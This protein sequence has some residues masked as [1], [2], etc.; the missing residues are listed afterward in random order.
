MQIGAIR[1]ATAYA[2]FKKARWP[3]TDGKPFCPHCGTL[4]CYELTDSRFKSS[5]RECRAVFTVTSGTAFAWRKLSFKKMLL[6]IWLV[7]NSVKGKAALQLS[8]ELG[9]AYKTAYVLLMK[10]REVVAARRGDMKLDGEVGIDGKYARGHVRPENRAEDRVDRRRRN[11]NR[12]PDRLCAL[13]VRQRGVPGQTLTRVIRGEDAK[14]AWAAVRDHVGRT[15]TVFADEHSS[16]DDLVGLNLVNRVNHS[17]ACRSEDGA[18]TN[19]VESFFSRLERAYVGIQHRFS[20]RYIDWYV[21]DIAW[22]ED[23]RRTSNGGLT[24]SLLGQALKRPTSRY[25]CGYWQG[26][27]PPIMVWKEPR[28]AR[29]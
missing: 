11:A 20:T 9:L 6:A 23:T 10:L 29:C 25:L 17:T 3:E 1:E 18:N 5:A 4:R 26:N 7:A 15:A 16:Y 2:W 28:T 27:K 14:A 12:S 8:R 22:R 19:Q 21:A 13:A 24:Q